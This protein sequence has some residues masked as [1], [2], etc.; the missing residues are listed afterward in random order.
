[1][2]IHE[3]QAKDIFSQA[4]IPIPR[5]RVAFTPQEA[6]SIAGEI[7]GRVVVKSQV[8]VGGRGKAGG[9]KLADSPTDAEKVAGQILGMD[10]KGLTVEKVLVEEAV[11]IRQEIYL[12]IVLDRARKAPTLILSAAGGVEIEVVA[13]E[14]PEKVRKLTLHPTLGI[15]PFQTRQAAYFLGL[16]KETHKA[17][18]QILIQLAIV[19]TQYDCSLAEINPLVITGSG[20]VLACDA[21][22]NF[23]DNAL[24]RHPELANLRDAAEE[25]PLETE[26]RNH[27]LSY[28]KLDG[29]VGCMVNG[30]GLAMT[31]MDMIKLSGGE[32]ANFLDVGGGA[33]VERVAQAFKILMADPKVKSVLI[34]IFGGI[35]RCDRVANGIIQA[36]NEV[37]VSVPVVVRLLGT[38][39]EEGRRI[40]GESKLD[41]IVAEGLKEAAEKAVK[42]AA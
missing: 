42:A 2:K 35:V 36:L 17:F 7:G 30:A 11:D 22:I 37:D 23:D 1:M 20:S 29:T 40:L 38:N 19:F 13:K 33:S 21:K 41:F 26:A 6:R 15:L 18:Q 8:L 9:V 28:I 34:N 31:T 10:I 5:G 39:A 4:G 12:G 16:P 27:N 14:T 24:F 32:P 3:Y 25:D